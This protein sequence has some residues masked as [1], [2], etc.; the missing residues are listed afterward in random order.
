MVE[1]TVGLQGWLATM[2]VL[3]GG[4]GNKARLGMGTGEGQRCAATDL[5]DASTIRG[6]RGREE[7]REGQRIT[8]L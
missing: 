2:A 4:V 3:H 1:T 7:E 8:I 5:G 6:K